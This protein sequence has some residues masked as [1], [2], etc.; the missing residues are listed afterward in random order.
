MSQSAQHI[1][2]VDPR[3]PRFGAAVTVVVLGAILILGP[4]S[5]VA[6]VLLTI[7]LLAFAAGA[8]LGL[9]AQPYGAFFKKFV[10]PRL[11]APTELEDSRPPQFAQAVGL[12][13]A[14]LGTVGW[15]L[16]SPVLFYVALG[17]AFA[18][19]FLNAAFNY[20]L[21]CEMYLLLQRTRSGASGTDANVTDSSTTSVSQVSHH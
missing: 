14:L 16:G 11:A 2:Q 21:G 19:A 6:G 9:G 15:I 4:R 20:C 10:R 18:A 13:F 8:V 17:A 5:A 12:G 1:T 3:G 7:Q